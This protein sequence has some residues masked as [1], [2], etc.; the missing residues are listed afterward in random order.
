MYDISVPELTSAEKR[1]LGVFVA[2]HVASLLSAVLLL[3][4]GAL[5]PSV[6]KW[7]FSA[8]FVL[9]IV[10][11]GLYVP[12]TVMLGGVADELLPPDQK[13]QWARRFR[14]EPWAFVAFWWKYLR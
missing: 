1:V 4:W 2:F 9:L 12:L 6:A 5:L 10:A 3:L 14:R 7:G 11:A 8:G 13:Y